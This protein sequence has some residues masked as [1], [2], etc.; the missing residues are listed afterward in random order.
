MGENVEQRTHRIPGMLSLSF[1]RSRDDGETIK[2]RTKGPRQRSR[3]DRE[4]RDEPLVTSHHLH[5]LPIVTGFR[6]LSS[7]VLGEDVP[8]G[9]VPMVFIVE[10]G[11]LSKL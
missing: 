5:S 7:Q 10:C 8:F 4:P 2:A 1:L 9:I 3:I 6:L 11:V